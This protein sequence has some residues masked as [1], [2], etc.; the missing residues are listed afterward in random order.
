MA[1]DEP[2]SNDE[3]YDIEGFKYIVSKDL[4]EKAQPIKV[5]F[6]EVG[7]KLTSSLVFDAGASACGSCA[8]NSSCCST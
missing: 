7:F 2:N 1:L 6:L 3:V 5:D 4:L 8:T